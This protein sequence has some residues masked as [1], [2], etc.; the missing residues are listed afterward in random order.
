M[1]NPAKT[2]TRTWS[3]AM[4]AKLIERGDRPEQTREIPMSQDEFLI[5]RGADCDLRLRISSISRHHCMIRLGNAEAT[6]LDLGSSN[7]TFVNG[8]RVRSQA[9]LQ[10]G[11]ELQVG[12]CKF[13]VE[14]GGSDQI[15]VDTAFGTD[16]SKTTAKLPPEV[17]ARQ[18]P[19]SQPPDAPAP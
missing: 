7:G 1:R 6:V 11:D 18:K 4:K 3:F 19:P 14:L 15:D 8:Q 9:T 2:R 16:P 5:G 17:L 10:N 12:T 13:I